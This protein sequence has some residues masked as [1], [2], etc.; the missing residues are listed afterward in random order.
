[1]TKEKIITKYLLFAFSKKIF[2]VT[3][4]WFPENKLEPLW[5][6]LFRNRNY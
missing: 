3:L 4:G 2:F 6:L 1:M 5:Y